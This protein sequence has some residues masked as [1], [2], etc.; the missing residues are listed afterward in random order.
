MLRKV[1]CYSEQVVVV[2][3]RE[4]RR[5]L[6]LKPLEVLDLA[7]FVV[8][9][10]DVRFGYVVVV[11]VVLDLQREEGVVRGVLDDRF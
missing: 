1:L 6:L 7:V 10:V 9:G 8:V 3:H 2:Q 11:S 4:V 5:T